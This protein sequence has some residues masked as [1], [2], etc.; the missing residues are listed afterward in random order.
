MKRSVA[1]IACLIVLLLYHTHVPVALAA[2]VTAQS[3]EQ[4]ENALRGGD[5]PLAAELYRALAEESP[6]QG[7]YWYR[8]AGA[9]YG[10]KQY[11]DAIGH[12][13]RAIGVG[14]AVGTSYYNTACCYA[15][16]GQSA[17]AIDNLEL[18]IRNGMRDRERLIREDTDFDTIRNTPAFQKRILPSVAG[19][20]RNEGWRID[21]AY[22][23]GRVGETHYDPF[24]YISEDEWNQEIARIS[25]AVPD[26][27]DT[28]III[29]LTA[30]MVRIN[31]GHTAMF[32]PTEGPNAFHSLPV[33]FYDFKDGLYVRGASGA[34]AGLVGK[35]VVR[36]GDTPAD[37][38]FESVATLVPRDNTQGIRWL[39]AIRMGNVEA[40]VTLGLAPAGETVNVTVKNDDGSE[41]MVAVKPV[42]SAQRH[43]INR[44]ADWQDMS[45][46]ASAPL[47]L[48]RKNK[49]KNYWFESLPERGMVY[50][51]FNSVRDQDDE[52][53]TEFSGR[54]FEF[55]NSNPVNVLVIDVR[56]NPG[57]NNTLARSFMLDIINSDK[58][59]QN[60]H[61]FVITGRETFSACQNFCNWLERDA[62]VM[63]V[64]EGNE[65][66]LP[67]SGLRANASSRLWQDSFSED[68]RHWIAP[69][70]GAEMTADDYRSNRDPA[71]DAILVYLGTGNA[72]ASS[73]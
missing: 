18:A 26:M 23:S 1:F 61:L 42:A 39:S 49:D 24:R 29:A 45:D 40:L 48:W 43:H 6:W 53:L 66:L 51:G 3:L 50:V 63:F 7:S 57:G 5:Y 34:Y 70:L 44:T 38:V 19:V 72:A 64:G 56:N 59:N 10:L 4:A 2:P 13:A 12:Y 28:E 31:D 16:M 73:N 25:Q 14:F 9:E 11:D 54:L 17:P 47:P 67:Y 52:S 46:D 32:S 15:L 8:L 21:L 68:Q 62:N 27:T 60:G 36:V 55:I 58:I 20:S 69:Y 65:I 71:M 37:Q 33:E 35:R 22:L 30:L 41:T